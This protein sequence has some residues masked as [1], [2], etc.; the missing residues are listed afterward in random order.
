MK[1]KRTM[2]LAALLMATMTVQ[3]QVCN[4]LLPST[5]PDSR[6]QMVSGS[7]GQQILD[8]RTQLIW[9]R[10]LIG[11]TWNGT[12][13]SGTAQKLGWDE[14]LKQAHAYSSSISW[15]LANIKELQSLIEEQCSDT[16]LNQRMFP[17]GSE[18]LWSSTPFAVQTGQDQSAIWGLNTKDGM[19]EPQLTNLKLAGWAVKSRN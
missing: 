18:L 17:V 1:F 9:Q 14:A 16:A 8:T 12:T 19:I 5:A 11:Q 7:N 3:A 6:F 13:C 2:T 15:R 10:C 4:S